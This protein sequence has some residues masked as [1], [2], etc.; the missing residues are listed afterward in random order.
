MKSKARPQHRPLKERLAA[1]IQ[2]NVQPGGI[3]SARV[4][5]I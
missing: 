3:E 4:E 5:E 1:S 2:E